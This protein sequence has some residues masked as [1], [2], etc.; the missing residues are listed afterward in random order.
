MEEIFLR[1]FSVVVLV[2]LAVVS[3]G[4]TQETVEQETVETE[5]WFQG[6]PIRDVVFDGLRHISATELDGITAPYKNVAFTDD[7]FYELT[8]RLYTLEYFDEITPAMIPVDNRTGVRIEFHVTERPTV[9]KIVFLGNSRLHRRDLISVVSVKPHDVVNQIKLKL[10]ESAILNKY[11]AEG[12]SSIKVRHEI[13]EPDKNGTVV[14]TFH[15]N[16]GEKTSI[17]AFV[18]QGNEVFSTKTLQGQLTS[19]VKTWINDGAFSEAK[20]LADQQAIVKYYYDRG[21]MDAKITD[22]T[23]TITSDGKGNNSMTITF[24][25]SEG[26]QYRFGGVEFEGNDIFSTETL[27][28]LVRSI[29]GELINGTRLSADLQR[30]SDKYYEN[31]Y[32]FNTIDIQEKRENGV[33]SFKIVI[34]ERERA[35]IESIKIQG[36]DKTKDSVI[37][38][39]IPLES[40]DIFSRSKV[41]DG[42][43]NLYNL[44]FFSSVIPD[45][46]Q[47]S[48]ENLMNLIF[49]VEEQ[50]TKDL[51]FG[52][53]FSGTSDPDTF[54]MSGLLKWSDRNFL[55]GGNAIGAELNASPDTQSLSLEYTQR[56]L[57]GLPLSVSFDLT[58]QHSLRNA[59]MDSFAPYFKGDEDY[60]YPD[61]F[62]S[63]DDY[64]NAG[65][66]PPNEFLMKYDQWKISFGIG[67]GYRWP[68]PIGNLSLGGGLRLGFIYNNYDSDLYRPFDPTI[69]E[70]NNRWTPAN[71]LWSVV[72]LDQRDIYYDPAQGYYAS[73]RLGYYG[74]LSME[75]EHYIQSDTKAEFFWTPFDIPVG[76]KW[77][78]KTTLGFHTGVSFIFS[79]PSYE[80]PVI[81]NANKLAI[82]GTFTGRGWGSEYSN[83][84]FALWENW[85]ELRIPLIPRVLAWDFFFD[86]AEVQPDWSTFWR[87]TDFVS[88]MRFSF[89]G[90]LRFT[91]PQFP[92]R[93]S[94]A[95]RFKIVDGKIDWQK[96]TAFGMDP[97]LSIALSSY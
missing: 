53:T 96:G 30:I 3:S 5:E 22:T 31:G 58:A 35:H 9:N 49:A 43:R 60:D 83:K 25:I 15:I 69:R 97:V 57:F 74:L 81:E 11:I 14:V 66:I 90:G 34:V 33:L 77:S 67:T 1:R 27:S 26:V 56:Y 63:Y 8:A 84:G 20:L 88:N 82:D 16:E 65:K 13:G 37:L 87:G 93:F 45:M 19:K 12:F 46:Q 52:I 24:N 89:G 76:E 95:K 29:P 40:G 18:F 71:S 61:G 55:G 36:N 44:Q 86:M 73:E 92:L 62:D 54:P 85:V 38:R 79:K 2:I 68:T 50:P 70:R 39:E 7:I 47:G 4:F 10:D 41:M 28:G 59:A 23:R 42:L 64:V 48:D 78:F 6:K 80:K 91:I 72:S 75:P 21:Y 51:Q 94:F 32:I 17:A